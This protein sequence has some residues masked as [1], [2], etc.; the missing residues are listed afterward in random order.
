MRAELRTRQGTSLAILVT[1]GSGHLGANV[2]RRLVEVGERVIALERPGTNNRA[3]DG[4]A[5]DRVQGDLRDLSSIRRAVHGVRQIYHCA[6]KVSTADDEEQELYDCNVVGTR[7]LLNAAR[8]AGVKRVVVTSSL[9]AVGHAIDRPAIESDV[10]FPFADHTPYERSKAWAEYECLKAVIAGLN[11]VIATSCA[12]VGPVDFKPSRI[13]QLIM[14]FANGRLCAYV[15]GGVEFVAVRDIVQGHLLA[16]ARGRSGQKY[17]FSTEFVEVDD[18]MSMLERITGRRRPRLR[19]PAPIMAGFASIGG[20]L[21]ARGF[22]V[23]PRRFTRGAV[24][25]LRTSRRASIAKARRELGYSPT[26]V[27]DALVEAYEWFVS[28]GEIKRPPSA[29]VRAPLRPRQ[30]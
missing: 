24:R 8:A 5:I 22:P 27:E 3:L 30:G 15:P 16:M 17:I 11:V 26:S 13:G 6:A 9:G 7:N 14:D 10:F 12:I 21:S 29:A 23:A 25:V 1:G 4:L 18:L 2:L 28:R 20:F 19:L